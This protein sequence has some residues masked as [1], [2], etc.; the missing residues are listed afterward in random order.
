MDFWTCSGTLKKNKKGFIIWNLQPLNCVTYCNQMA[1]C[2]HSN[3]RKKKKKDITHIFI[4]FDVW[5]L[6]SSTQLR[7]AANYFISHLCIIKTHCVYWLCVRENVCARREMEQK[8]RTEFR[9]CPFCFKTYTDNRCKTERRKV[10]TTKKIVMETI[11]VVCDLM[12]SLGV[13][14]VFLNLHHLLDVP[15]Y[16][17]SDVNPNNILIPFLFFL[18]FPVDIRREHFSQLSRGSVWSEWFPWC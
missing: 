6:V 13:D 5:E 14:V 7:M 8:K 17:S 15:S 2:N 3:S 16:P 9:L 11:H 18:F 4:A 1:A 10:L 12:W